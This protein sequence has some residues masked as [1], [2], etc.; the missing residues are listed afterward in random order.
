MLSIN[1]AS[2]SALISIHI[3]ARKLVISYN[4]P[5]SRNNCSS[6]CKCGS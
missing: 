2:D 5:G 6:D 1:A 4:A 3:V